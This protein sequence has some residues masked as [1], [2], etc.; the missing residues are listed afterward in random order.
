MNKA[1]TI[2]AILKADEETKNAIIK[3][4]Y[5]DRR[6]Q[7]R[8]ARE[9]KGKNPGEIIEIIRGWKYGTKETL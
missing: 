3:L 7:K 9:T 5:A 1:E 4:L 2:N 8:I 6:T